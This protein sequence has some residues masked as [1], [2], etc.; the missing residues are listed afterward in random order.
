[1][2]ILKQ[3]ISGLRQIATMSPEQMA[4]PAASPLARNTGQA[5][6]RETTS[7]IQSGTRRRASEYDLEAEKKDIALAKSDTG[8]AVGIGVADVALKGLTA[9]DRMLMA[10]KEEEDTR[11]MQEKYDMLLKEM[12]ENREIRNRLTPQNPTGA[13]PG[14]SSTLDYIAR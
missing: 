4:V 12:K 1:M 11:I 13:T 14:T 2:S 9:R 8:A 6:G 7:E 3:Y 5:M 10:A